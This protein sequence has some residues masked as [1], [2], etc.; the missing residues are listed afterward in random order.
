MNAFLKD[1][2]NINKNISKRKAIIGGGN[3]YLDLN[4]DSFLTLFKKK[5]KEIFK[6]IFFFPYEIL[7]AYKFLFKIFKLKKS[8]TNKNVL[9]L[10]NGL[11]IQVPYHFK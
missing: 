3:F 1:Y 4:P 5:I 7:V 8:K 6:V 2:L 9:I 10:V 11:N